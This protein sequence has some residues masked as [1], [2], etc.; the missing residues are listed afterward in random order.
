MSSVPHQMN[1]GWLVLSRMRTAVRKLCGQDSGLPSGVADQSWARVNAPIS[2]PPARKSAEGGRLNFNIGVDR[3]P[4]PSIASRNL[5]ACHTPGKRAGMRPVPNYFSPER[6][7]FAD[8]RAAGRHPCGGRLYFI[9]PA[10]VSARVMTAPTAMARRPCWRG[11]LGARITV[12]SGHSTWE[13]SGIGTDAGGGIGMTFA[14]SAAGGGD[15][16]LAGCLLAACLF[17]DC[18]LAASLG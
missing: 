9:R 12:A 17:A 5:P 6:N 15:G 10:A 16:G 4:S 13:T 3:W 18:L 14:A 2:P 1:I 7:E 11:R 8:A